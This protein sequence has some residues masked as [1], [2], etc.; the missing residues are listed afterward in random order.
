MK[1]FT[2]QPESVL[3]QIDK[4]GFYTCN[5]NK[6]EF[7]DVNDKNKEYN[8]IYNAYN[9]L[10]KEMNKRIDNKERIEYPVWAWYKFKDYNFNDFAMY[11]KDTLYFLEIEIPDK[12]VVLT[13]YNTWHMVLNN[14]VILEDDD[15]FDAK[16]ERLEHL[17]SSEYE[18]EKLSSWEKIFLDK[19][20][21]CD[22]IQATFFILKKDNIKNILEIKH[23]MDVEMLA[24]D[25]KEGEKIN[26]DNLSDFK[27]NLENYKEN[28]INTYKYKN[29]CTEFD[30]I[31]KDIFT[32]EQKENIQ[33]IENYI[34]KEKTLER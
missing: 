29:N 5:I 13:D 1:L 28:L 25:I 10:S 3:E 8:R 24:Y 14:T 9:Y 2:I 34:S 30:L 26:I 4:Y 33:I 16:W 18:K 31:G 21:D 32:N 20:S 22:Y 27:E 12:D 17:S 23:T 7:V 6:S 19:D 11:N 15:N